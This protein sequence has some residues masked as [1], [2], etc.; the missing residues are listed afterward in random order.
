M[1]CHTHWTIVQAAAREAKS[2]Q[3]AAREAKNAAREECF[4]ALKV[5]GF[6]VHAANVM[7]ALKESLKAISILSDAAITKFC[8]EIRKTGG[9]PVTL[10]A[11]NNLKMLVYYYRYLLRT[12]N[13]FDVRMLTLKT[14]WS[15][16]LLRRFEIQHRE[17]EDFPEID[18][19]NWP[20]T[21]AA[22][23]Q[24]F[25]SCHGLQ[26]VPL[27]Y[28]IRPDVAPKP[29][30]GG[31]ESAAHELVARAPIVLDATDN[32]R[33]LYLASFK[34]DNTALWHKIAAMTRHTSCWKLIRLYENTQDAH[35]AFWLLENHY[36]RPGLVKAARVQRQ[37]VKDPYLPWRRHL[38]CTNRRIRKTSKED[39][40]LARACGFRIEFEDGSFFL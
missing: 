15:L 8:D 9:T 30:C 20:R 28:V 26:H 34:K 39:L 18:E 37:T 14:I 23:R 16:K 2:A 7:S 21:I 24:Y 5:V 10:Q 27:A 29:R 13:T 19:T 6:S 36:L 25:Y 38:R 12:S 40:I 3:A 11:E 32:K 33:P 4:T 35:K 1:D 22:M 17:P 31:W